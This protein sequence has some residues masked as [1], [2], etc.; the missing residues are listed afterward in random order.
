[1]PDK[2][3][4]LNVDDSELKRKLQEE[5]A[6]AEK[7]EETL[8]RSAG[9]QSATGQG[10]PGQSAG[11]GTATAAR[12]SA[13]VASTASSAMPVAMNSAMQNTAASGMMV[14]PAVAGMAGG[15]SG[16]N[17][18]MAFAMA[19]SSASAI[20]YGGAGGFM[21]SPSAQ[22]GFNQM[23]GGYSLRQQVRFGREFAN[24]AGDMAQLANI[25]DTRNDTLTTSRYGMYSSIASTAIG[26]IGGLATGN[27]M[28]GAGIGAA[29]NAVLGPLAQY[30]GRPDD[31]KATAGRTLTPFMGAYSGL[32]GGAVI[33]SLMTGT[34]AINPYAPPGTNPIEWQASRLGAL[35]YAANANGRLPENLQFAMPRG[36]PDPALSATYGAVAAG[37]FAGG[38]DPM[39]RG[40]NLPGGFAYPY[41]NNTVQNRRGGLIDTLIGVAGTAAAGVRVATGGQE[42]LS[43]TFT[44]RLGTLFGNESPVVAKQIA[45]IFG[46]LPETGG[47]M[48]DILMKYGAQ[49]TATFSRLQNDSLQSS[50]DPMTLATT[51]AN[52]RTGQRLQR[53]GSLSIRGSGLAQAIALRGQMSDI[54]SLPGGSDSMAFAEARNAYAGALTTAGQ[55]SDITNFGI[56]GVQLQGQ[57]TRMQMM[58]Y[59]PSRAFELSGRQIQNNMGQIGALRSRMNTMRSA[60][61]LSEETELA[62]T[63]QIEGLR[64]QNAQD[65]AYLSEG[66]ENMIP[67]LV[68]GRRRTTGSYDSANLAAFAY[69]RG[70]VPFRNAGAVNGRQLGM[71]NAY[72]DMIG[73]GEG[74]IFPRSR[75]QG[76][77][78]GG[79]AGGGFGT[80]GIESLLSQLLQVVKGGGGNLQGSRNS[81]PIGQTYGE[82]QTRNIGQ[83]NN[84]VS[85]G[86]Q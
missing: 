49:D 20:A 60:G 72:S 44:R 86:Y 55:Q 10:Q 25:N 47:N 82:Q 3:L 43:E 38:L 62:M 51:S 40:A 27:P 4:K 15:M 19:G 28:A 36:A 83:G 48:A 61:Y 84:S 33:A 53:L 1:M 81:G 45:P 21:P 59:A 54:S 7:L 68:A 69:A 16:A 85:R 31:Y 80:A 56:T 42:T 79:M 76:M 32:Q 30:L 78:T 74:D 35:G 57:M 11:M 41:A 64:N 70:G 2:E 71:Q 22:G 9:A 29:A 14:A 5:I 67:G 66:R 12:A 23:F 8:K 34:P 73:L 17:P 75:S 37:L 39:G 46:A 58:P 77:N 50:V 63:S 26:V 52:I 65:F 13:A 18:A 6:L 24:I